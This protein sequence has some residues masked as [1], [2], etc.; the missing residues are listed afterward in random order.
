MSVFDL[1]YHVH[2]HQWLFDFCSAYGCIYDDPFN[3]GL[4]GMISFPLNTSLEKE[5]QNISVKITTKE[6]ILLNFHLRDEKLNS[7]A[8]FVS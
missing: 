8:P 7:E 2:D 6:W 3:S 1:H 4:K 5:M